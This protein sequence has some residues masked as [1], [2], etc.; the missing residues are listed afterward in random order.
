LNTEQLYSPQDYALAFQKGNEQALRYFYLEF[1]PTLAF[2][3]NRW[4]N[5]RLVAEEIASE[6]FMKIWKRHQ[7]FTDAKA[8]RSYLY[9]IV[10]NDSFKWLKK[11]REEAAAYKAIANLES[12]YQKDHFQFLVAAETSRQLRETISLLPPEC[13]RVFRLLYIEGKSVKETAET[14][15]LS[16]STVKTQKARGL[17]TIRKRFAA[18]LQSIILYFLLIYI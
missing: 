1:H 10:K 14:L 6:A 7:Q 4:V 8:I 16:P 13:E 9:R 11:T 15:S 17:A 2:Y 5:N 3:S 18:I 12:G